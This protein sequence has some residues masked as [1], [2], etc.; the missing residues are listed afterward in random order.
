MEGDEGFSEK[1]E[2]NLKDRKG[3]RKISFKEKNKG[4]Y[5]FKNEGLMND[6]NDNKR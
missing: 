4:K 1:I 6:S 5:N 2:N 3:V